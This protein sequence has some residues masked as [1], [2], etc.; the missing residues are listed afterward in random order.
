MHNTDS[1]SSSPTVAVITSTIGRPDLERAI[2]SVKNQSYPCKHYVFVDGS[3]FADAAKLILDRHP[4]VIATYLPMNTGANGWTNCSVNAIAPFLVK[5][6]IICYLDDDN[7]YE[8]NH[9]ESIIHAFQ[10]HDPDYVYSLRNFFNKKQEFICIDNLESLGK[11]SNNLPTSNKFNIKHQGKIIQFDILGFQKDHIDTNCYA[12]KRHVALEISKAWYS[13]K[14]NDLH[15]ARTLNNLKYQSVCSGAVTVNYYL[16]YAK[17]FA[18]IYEDLLDIMKGDVTLTDNIC[19]ETLKY[20]SQIS[21]NIL[22]G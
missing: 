2:L 17:M 11:L 14:R 15:V 7:W 12:F 22:V 6:E 19:E 9:I 18:G 5:E 16:E 4:N 21:G 1:L 13:G 3:Q 20:L 8:P 10:K